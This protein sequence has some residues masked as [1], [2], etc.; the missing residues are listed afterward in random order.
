MREPKIVSID[1]LNKAVEIKIGGK[2]FVISRLTMR[3]TE[4]YGEYL[5]FCGEYAKKVNATKLLADD[6]GVDLPGLEKIDADMQKL[7][8]DF[9]IE[10]AERIEEMLKTILVKN[11]Y[12]FDLEWW[13]NNATYQDMEMFIF[14][15]LKKDED[16]APKKKQ[17]ES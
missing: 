13:H 17:A 4:L 12:E 1:D 3:I 8:E 14:Q 15:S 7:V 2:S 11:G 5:I 10:K 9:S 6:S 16:E